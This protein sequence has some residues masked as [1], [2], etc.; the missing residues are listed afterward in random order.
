M[1]TRLPIS[2]PLLLVLIGLIIGASLGLGS[3]Y[4]VFYPSMIKERTQTLEERVGGIEDNVNLIGV[5]LDE[6][7]TSMSVIGNTLDSILALSDVIDQISTRVTAIETGAAPSSGATDPF[8]T[9]CA[10]ELRRVQ[11]LP[12][13]SV[14]A[15]GDR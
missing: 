3:G 8:G 9:L 5:Q 7:N 15:P 13:R 12:R 6:M 14:G 2:K 4:A 11:Q 10:A 1:Q